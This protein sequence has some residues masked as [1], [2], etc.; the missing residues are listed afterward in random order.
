MA[1]D[2]AR[3]RQQWPRA[4]HPMLKFLTSEWYKIKQ[5]VF[6]SFQEDGTDRSSS[7]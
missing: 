3:V 7:D 5:R 6:I 4:C 1:D 2:E